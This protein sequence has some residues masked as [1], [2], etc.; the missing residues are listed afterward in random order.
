MRWV[1]LSDFA[2]ATPCIETP[3]S[4]LLYEECRR[5]QPCSGLATAIG[6]LPIRPKLPEVPRGLNDFLE[7]SRSS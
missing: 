6:F 1:L 2:Q 4:Q 7:S 5:I 3:K